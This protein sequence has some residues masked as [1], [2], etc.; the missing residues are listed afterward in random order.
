VNSKKPRSKKKHV[1]IQ[2]LRSV[3]APKILQVKFLVKENRLRMASNKTKIPGKMRRI[4][5]AEAGT[6]EENLFECA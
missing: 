3:L 2:W 4:A 6:S 5:S 1:G